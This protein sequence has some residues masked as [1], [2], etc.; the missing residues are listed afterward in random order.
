MIFTIQEDEN[1]HLWLGTNGQGLDKF[2]AE[3]A[4]AEHFTTGNGLPGNEILSI[5]EDSDKNLWLT[6]NG[7]LC[8]INPSTQKV[9]SFINGNGIENNSFNPNAAMAHENGELYFGGTNGFIRFHPEEISYNPVP[10]STIITHFYIHNKE[11]MPENENGI[12][13]GQQSCNRV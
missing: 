8:V 7:G 5:L 4:I 1:G 2:N 13:Q 10:P 11:I 6:T 9:R 12:S 3:T